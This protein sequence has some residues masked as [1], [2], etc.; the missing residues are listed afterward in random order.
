[1]GQK[2]RNI[3]YLILLLILLL[4]AGNETRIKFKVASWDE[5]LMVHVYAVNGDDRDATGLYIE[6]LRVA[7]F[8]PIEVFVNQQARRYGITVDAIRVYYGGELFEKPPQPPGRGSVSVFKNI[9]W[10]LH[11]RAW[12]WYWENTVGPGDADI[13]LFVNYFD[14]ATT[15]ALQHSVGLRGGLIGLINAFADHS[16]R[17]SNNVVITHELMHTFGAADKYGAGNQPLHPDG[18]ADPFQDPLYPQTRAEIMG[19][20]IPINASQSKIPNSLADVVVQVFTASEIRW[21]VQ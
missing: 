19:G 6:Q 3:R 5:T 17:G 18:Y 11:F 13:N 7:D 8:K 2:S 14:G 10:S 15:E 1:M 12:A 16:Y 20:R 4:I 21:P 9:V